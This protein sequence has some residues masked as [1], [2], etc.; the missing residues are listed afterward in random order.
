[1]RLLGHGIALGL[2]HLR[3]EE[4]RFGAE[5]DAVRL[6]ANRASMPSRMAGRS[7]VM[8]PSD[9]VCSTSKGIGGRSLSRPAMDTVTTLRARLAR[10]ASE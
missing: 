10:Q 3:V 7:A 2:E 9:T 8:S 4:V 5:G 6:R 1:M